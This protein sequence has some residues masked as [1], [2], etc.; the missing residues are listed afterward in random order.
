M[1]EDPRKYQGVHVHQKNKLS[2]KF[3]NINRKHKANIDSFFSLERH[4]KTLEWP[5]PPDSTQTAV[6]GKLPD[7]IQLSGKCKAFIESMDISHGLNSKEKSNNI[8]IA[9][10][11]DSESDLAIGACDSEDNFKLSLK[12]PAN[13]SEI[14]K[15][16]SFIDLTD[17]ETG[18]RKLFPLQTCGV[19]VS[20]LKSGNLVERCPD[21]F[22]EGLSTQLHVKCDNANDL[23]I[24]LFKKSALR[25]V[26]VYNEALASMSQRIIDDLHDNSLKYPTCAESLVQGLTTAPFIGM[27]SLGIPPVS[28][29][30][31][32]LGAHINSMDRTL[33]I[34][35][36]CY[37]FASA[38]MHSNLDMKKINDMLDSDDG[39][40]KNDHFVHFLGDVL[41]AFTKDAACV[42]Y[43]RD[44]TPTVGIQGFPFNIHMGLCMN[45]TE[46]MS[47]LMDSVQMYL[48]GDKDCK[49]RKKPVVSDDST[50]P[51]LQETFN[52]TKWHP[53][54]RGL[55]MDDCESTSYM[56]LALYNTIKNEDFSEGNI[57]EKLSKCTCFKNLTSHC[58][59]TLSRFFTVFKEGIR[60]NKI[61][62]STIVGMAGGASASE[63]KDSQEDQE[64]IQNMQAG[65]HCFA[66][67]RVI[68][69]DSGKINF[70]T[71]EGTNATSFLH[72]DDMVK[73]KV[74][75]T[76][77]TENI[78]KN[79]KEWHSVDS[80]MLLNLGARTLAE[81]TKICANEVGVSTE[82]DWAPSS[83]ASK[84]SSENVNKGH[85]RAQITLNMSKIAF[86][87]WVQ[88]VGFSLDPKAYSFIPCGRDSPDDDLSTWF[89]CVPSEAV[90]SKL[91]GIYVSHDVL[92]PEIKQL[93]DDI[94]KEVYRP[95][96]PEERFHEIMGYWA[97]LPPL[98]TI[99][100]DIDIDPSKRYVIMACMHSPASPFL[101][102]L[103]YKAQS[104]LAEETNRLQKLERHRG[105][106]IVM[107][108][109]KSGTGTSNKLWVPVENGLE[110][111]IFKNLKQARDNIGYNME[112]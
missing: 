78:K 6:H 12:C 14:L 105:D 93:G 83:D 82:F 85:C 22:N 30:Y 40:L 59:N 103:Q 106:G 28:S 25:N 84:P 63:A 26:S 56:I 89:G 29:H 2:T 57:R 47:F 112:K 104:L 66:G 8:Y 4:R 71:L 16:G 45:T 107:Q 88:F 61:Q 60:D 1:L 42:P 36:P 20:D 54:F 49:R 97:D 5:D 69:H 94:M 72:N 31:S 70:I 17:E 7:H 65:G 10:W 68:D 55:G 87:K 3:Q 46:D 92:A 98:D 53:V 44:A 102:D 38:L 101:V 35:L 90:D 34:T 62:V 64:D 50:I 41:T 19:H 9:C 109:I 100:R 23:I 96:A 11:F 111:N 99:N 77:D 95:F 108:V 37:F 76:G 24:P 51:E 80:T 43:Q 48:A 21:S 18:Q 13:P 74:R 75:F 79:K 52:S 67:L 33:P 39:P 58:H 91:N 15:V 73:Y 32:L 27:P 110:I 86:Y 81:M